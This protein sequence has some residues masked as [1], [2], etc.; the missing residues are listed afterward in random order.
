MGLPTL[1]QSPPV[2]LWSKVTTSP[3][4]SILCTFNTATATI[5]V[6]PLERATCCATIGLPSRGHCLLVERLQ[7]LSSGSSHG[8]VDCSGMCHLMMPLVLETPRTCFLQH[9][10]SNLS[11][12]W[13]CGRLDFRAHPSEQELVNKLVCLI[14]YIYVHVNLY[15]VYPPSNSGEKKQYWLL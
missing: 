3:D 11:P 15:I 10:R 9:C 7:K 13:Q 5:I 4:M 12:G 1:K 14:Y 2:Y 6:Q 8:I